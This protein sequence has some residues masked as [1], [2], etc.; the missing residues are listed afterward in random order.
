MK[1]AAVAA[2]QTIPLTEQ[3]QAVVN[4][5]V[6]PALVFAV[7][8]A[9]KTTAMV[10][11]IERLVR[12][13]L[14]APEQILATSFGR[15]N[16][17][18]LREALSPWPH[19]RHVDGRTLHSLG[20]DI[21][22]QA[23]Q[24][25]HLRHLHLNQQQNGDGNIEQHILSLAMAEARRQNLP[26]KKELEGL[27]RQD[28]LDYVG[29]CKG[30]LLYADFKRVDLPPAARNTAGQAPDPS[31]QLTW[32]LDLYRLF[33][34]IRLQQGGITFSDMLMTGWEAL[35][36]LPDV[37][38]Q[39]QQRYQTV[40]V[41]EFQDINLVQSEMLHLIA[42]PHGNYMAIGDDDQT[43]Y[44][45]RG[46]SPS[47]ILDFPKRYEASTYLISDNFR[48]PAAPL[49]LANRV[50]EK[51]TQ[52]QPKRL[53]LTRG[54]LGETA[55]HIDNNLT[56]M[57]RHIVQR[58]SKLHKGAMP[59][60]GI[61][62]LV[63]LNAQT[64]P[65]EQQLIEQNIPY[66]VSQPFYE[67]NEIKTIIQYCRI[68]WLEKELREG[69]RPFVNP[70]TRDT[71]DEA[72][73]SICNRPKR[74][75][76]NDLRRR[77]FD[78]V[79]RQGLPIS[80]VLHETAA[81]STQ[82]WL[83]EPL[84][85]LGDDITWLSNQLDK[86]AEKTLRLLDIRLDYQTFLRTSSGFQQTG[87]GRAISVAT[88][89]RYAKAHGSLLTF[90]THLRDLAR[91]KVGQATAEARDAVTLST[92]HQ[93]KGLEWPVVFVAQCNEN[94]MPFLS[95]R[96][97]D[98]AEQTAVLAEERR[99]LYVALTRTREHLHI[100]TLKKEPISR[101]L[102]EAIY[103]TVLADVPQIQAI[104]AKPPQ[105]W[106]A[107]EAYL[108]AKQISDFH[109]QRF[110]VHWWN[111]ADAEKTAV[112]QTILNFLHAADHHNLWPHLNL[113]QTHMDFWNAVTPSLSHAITPTSFPG[114]NK[115]KLSTQ[116]PGD[117]PTTTPP[118]PIL[119]EPDI[120]MP[121]MW[122]RCDAGWGRIEKILDMLKRPLPHTERTNSFVRY[123]ITLRPKQD[124]EPV[125]I[126]VSASR[127]RFTEAKQVFTC[128]KCNQFT[129]AT[130]ARVTNDHNHAV[131]NGVSP[132]FKPERKPE[133]KL[134]GLWFAV[135]EPEGMME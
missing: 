18:D 84:T 94:V 70:G 128:A 99:L 81:Q 24:M 92:I 78:A 118:P 110:F 45:W 132:A 17:V 51:N 134:H 36:R 16:V 61:A 6:G 9:G 67:R 20:R 62:V 127:I 100:H 10:H 5:D 76:N 90:M 87:E 106:Q 1:K 95:E 108:V 58:I 44:E 35:V 80:T 105:K 2:T 122:L 133:R 33:E 30:N 91:Q 93:A 47:F 123:I 117:R 22:K 4:H 52:R 14:F 39:V 31:E 23:Q 69:K 43:I 124:A 3:Q 72:W 103:P 41:D 83:R 125:E 113:T 15:A 131:H 98:V 119:D 56:Q 54:F 38:A 102:T 71:F 29:A 88:F 46:A 96:V 53:S 7:A 115:L 114:L 11:R 97:T 79:V 50:I 89:I 85:Q 13:G 28:F 40:L 77:L 130:E 75:I 26:Y 112:C 66:R 86:S 64:P 104:L 120:I 59:L 129:A 55:V 68:A 107:G 126:D 111:V 121:G 74:Y 27:D 34:Q 37:L 63:R 109:L 65:I 57:S 21:I 73:R 25:G 49:V 19:C 82:S 116:I 101:F 48:C 42:E 60:H 12:D 135:R 32:Y 8:G